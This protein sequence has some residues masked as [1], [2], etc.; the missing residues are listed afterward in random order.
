[1]HHIT[2][3]GFLF[4]FW[5]KLI[6][7][8]MVWELIVGIFTERLL[9]TVRYLSWD[10]VASPHWLEKNLRERLSIYLNLKNISLLRMMANDNM[11][12][13]QLS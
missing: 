9:R 5:R 13:E 8:H 3:G 4:L 6:Y 11:C 2:K 1:M 10:T 7:T 12:S